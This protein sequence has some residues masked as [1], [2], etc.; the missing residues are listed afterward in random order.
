MATRLA[1]TS[2]ASEAS[3]ISPPR[4]RGGAPQKESNVPG[5]P[6]YNKPS[7]GHG[8]PLSRMVSAFGKRLASSSANDVGDLS[9]A[10]SQLSSSPDLTSILE[11]DATIYMYRR[12]S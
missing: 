1:A 6:A 3:E 8:T 10:D 9:R 4:P 11:A 5:Y 7:C 2:P 12:P